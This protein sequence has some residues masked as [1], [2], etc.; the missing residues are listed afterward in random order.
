MKATQQRV[1]VK[2]KPSPPT[3]QSPLVASRV[4]KLHFRRERR[5]VLGRLVAVLVFVPRLPR[6]SHY[7]VTRLAAQRLLRR[8]AV[9]EPVVL[10]HD[11]VVA[12]RAAPDVVAGVVR[13]A[14]RDGLPAVAEGTVPVVRDAGRLFQA[15]AGEVEVLAWAGG[16]GAGDDVGGGWG[17]GRLCSR[18]FG[19]RW[20]VGLMGWGWE[21]VR[22]R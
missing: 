4:L 11:F 14:V 6:L 15:R 9:A 16:V 21:R 22:S 17:R 13:V 1:H 12:L 8:L 19:G 18:V 2:S 3:R 20:W 7:Q 10:V 5:A